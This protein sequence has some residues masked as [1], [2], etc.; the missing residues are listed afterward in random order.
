MESQLPTADLG[1]IWA[2]SDLTKDGYLDSDE[3]VLSQHLIR[4]RLAGIDLPDT[5]PQTLLPPKSKV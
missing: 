4:L 1:K 5:L 2:L 3:F